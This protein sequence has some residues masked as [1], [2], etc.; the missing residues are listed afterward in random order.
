ML[1]VERA[2][3]SAAEMRAR[4][5]AKLASAQAAAKMQKRA[6]VCVLQDVLLSRLLVGP[7]QRAQ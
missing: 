4:V 1:V 5:Q 2:Q 7:V 6:R 3:T